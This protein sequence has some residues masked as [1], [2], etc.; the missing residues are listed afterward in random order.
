MKMEWGSAA[1]RDKILG[2]WDP[3]EILYYLREGML[4]Q[5]LFTTS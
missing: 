4:C 5:F 1:R 2:L 3:H